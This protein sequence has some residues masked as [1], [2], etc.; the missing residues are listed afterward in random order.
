[1]RFVADDPPAALVDRMAQTFLKTDGD[2]REVMRTMLQS[3]EFWS[4]GAYRSKMKSPLEMVASAVRALNGDVDYAFPLVNQ[5][6][7]LDQ[8]L[9]RKPY[10]T[11]ES[12]SSRERV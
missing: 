2:L 7:Q 10:P 5:V 8:P 3:K 6:A 11:G 1:M 4:E 12:N 9:Y